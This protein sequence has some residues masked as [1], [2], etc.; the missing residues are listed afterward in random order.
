MTEREEK[1]IAEL[2]DLHIRLER[3]H[4]IAHALSSM[5]EDEPRTRRDFATLAIIIETESE[6]N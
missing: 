4:S 6:I 2:N 3:I 1:M 5:L